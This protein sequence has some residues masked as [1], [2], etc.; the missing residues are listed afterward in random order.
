M[1]SNISE[2]ALTKQRKKSKNVCNA[3]GTAWSGGKNVRGNNREFL[4][5]IIRKDAG[6]EQEPRIFHAPPQEGNGRF[7]AVHKNKRHSG[8]LRM[9]IALSAK[10]TFLT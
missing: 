5:K 6:R 1:G 3:H 7:S 8:I 10:K 4:W 2:R 9:K